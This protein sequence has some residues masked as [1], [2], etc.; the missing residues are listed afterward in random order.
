M[1]INK[2]I[3]QN[4]IYISNIVSINETFAQGQEQMLELNK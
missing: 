4:S 2:E 3:L 1:L